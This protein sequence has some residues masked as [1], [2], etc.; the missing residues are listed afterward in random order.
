MTPAQE[1]AIRT[2]K[3]EMFQSFDMSRGGGEYEYKLFRVNE[4]TQFASVVGEVGMKG[5]EGTLAELM[6]R[7]RIQLFVYRDGRITYPVWNGDKIAEKPLFKG[8]YNAVHV[9]QMP[10]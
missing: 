1:K 2:I 3:A 9:D 4:Y 6:C 8:C 10:R 5:D 7:S